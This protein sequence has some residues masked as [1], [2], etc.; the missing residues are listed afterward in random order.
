M[1]ASEGG[2]NDGNEIEILRRLST[3]EGAFSFEW[4]G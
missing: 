3:R 4:V 2:A 1:H